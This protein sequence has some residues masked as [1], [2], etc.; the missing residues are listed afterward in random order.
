MTEIYC[1]EYINKDQRKFR[2]KLFNNENRLI[3]VAV[4]YV[5]I[6]N[7]K[8]YEDNYHQAEYLIP[9]NIPELVETLKKLADSIII[10]VN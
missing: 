10:L 4:N 6:V 8:E 1:E 9:V 5:S 7:D 2:I 3:A